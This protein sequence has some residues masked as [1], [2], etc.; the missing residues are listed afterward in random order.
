MKKLILLLT[1]G[2]AVTSKAQFY[3]GSTYKT[4]YSNLTGATVLYNNNWDDFKKPIKLPFE[5]KYW[6]DKLTDS[7]YLRS[8]GTLSLNTFYSGH[9]SFISATMRSRGAGKTSVNYLVSGNAPNR[10]LKIE[11][12]NAGFSDDG[13][14]F[15]DSVNVQCWLY[16]TSNIIEF[17]YGPNSVKP[18]TWDKNEGT[19]GIV[20]K[21]VSKLVSMEGT[22][23]NPYINTNIMI[24]TRLDGLPP[25]GTVYKFTPSTGGIK[26]IPTRINIIDGKISLPSN[27][28]VKAILIYNNTGQLVQSSNTLEETDLSNLNQ[29]IYYIVISTSKGIISEK[30]FL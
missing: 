21:A 28:D 8:F 19:I 23:S 11:F 24:V 17:R 9:I 3:S 10:I 4:T 22:P 15:N 18:S 13:P 2:L 16:E 20:N 7:I 25:N 29:G 12:K 6:D 14:N 5:I 30:K 26:E 27:T 1:L